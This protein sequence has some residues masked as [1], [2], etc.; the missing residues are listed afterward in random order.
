MLPPWAILA[1]ETAPTQGSVAAVVTLVAQI[2]LSAIFLW[3]WRDERAERR[4]LQDKL[5][6]LIDRLHP[7]LRESTNT[8]ERVQRGMSAQVDRATDSGELDA[9][10]RNLEYQLRDFTRALDSFGGRAGRQRDDPSDGSAR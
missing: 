7:A 8:L 4:R 2:G 9:T 10:V 6:E 5:Y 1:Q 3:Q